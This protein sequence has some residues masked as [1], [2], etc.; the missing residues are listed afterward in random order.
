MDD[1]F[2]QGNLNDFYSEPAEYQIPALQ[3]PKLLHLLESEMGWHRN[4]NFYGLNCERGL[5]GTSEADSYSFEGLLN[6]QRSAICPRDQ[7]EPSAGMNGNHSTLVK[8]ESA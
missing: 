1:K 3:D 8:E 4:H 6:N 2:L 5:Y 7:L